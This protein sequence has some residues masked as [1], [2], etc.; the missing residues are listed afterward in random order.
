[1]T[2]LRIA[3]RYLFSRKR[4]NAVNVISWI[5]VAGVAVATAAIVCVLSVF[6]GFS[7]LAFSRLSEVD[8]DI[9]I[10]PASGKIFDSSDSLASHLAALPEFESAQ[11]VIEEKALAIYGA[12]QMPVT[13]KGVPDN[14]A[15]VSDIAGTIIDGEWLS[16]TG[17]Y[18]CSTLSVGVALSLN[19]RPGYYDLLRLYAPRRI[20]RVNTANPM[21][22]FRSDSL[23]VSAVYEIDQSEYDADKVIVPLASARKLLD[24]TDEAT[25]IELKLAPG[26]TTRQGMDAAGD[27]VGE[28]GIVMN[29]LMQQ[30]ESF[31]MI[32]VEKWIT[33]LM[34]AFILVIAS[35]NVLSIMSMLIIEK[36]DNI[37]TLMALGATPAMIRRIFMLEGWLISLLGGAVGLILGIA[38]C[39]IQQHWGLIKLGGDPSQLSV[40]VYPVQL[41]LSDLVAVS[42][43]VTATGF[44]IG[45]I[46]GGMSKPRKEM[47]RNED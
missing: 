32:S 34:L 10:V 2:S 24:Y 36:K 23:I 9:K 45:L 5:S 20:G 16:T 22:A 29:R 25:A 33:F 41:Q 1:M 13:I 15:A 4:H 11:P 14:Y 3:L 26:V 27:I 8:P 44:L 43:I 12:R 35:F 30:A 46:A 39:F 28:S 17:D 7:K 21:N 6:N 47:L 31:R 38:L 19:A 40:S 42:L 37:A 18:P